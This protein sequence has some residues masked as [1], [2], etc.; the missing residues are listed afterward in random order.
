MA[1]IDAE[2][3]ERALGLVGEYVPYAGSMSESEWQAHANALSLAMEAARAHLAHL[4]APKG[5]LE[6][7]RAELG[8]WLVEHPRHYIPDPMF[9]SNPKTGDKVLVIA[10]LVYE[11]GAYGFE[12]VA[13]GEGPTEAAAIRAALSRAR[14]EGT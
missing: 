11:D 7:A 1:E 5:E 12:V 9:G 2:E 8:A 13:S 4:R 14:G 6:E 3:L 10:R